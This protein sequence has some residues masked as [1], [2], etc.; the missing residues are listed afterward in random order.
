MALDSFS[1]SLAALAPD[2]CY[3]PEGCFAHPLVPS[4]NGQLASAIGLPQHSHEHRPKRP[5]L[6]AVDQK[7]GEGRDLTQISRPS[8]SVPLH[9]STGSL[10]RE[11]AGALVASSPEDLGDLHEADVLW[12]HIHLSYLD[13]C[14]GSRQ[15]A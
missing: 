7:L 11:R 9:R 8:S 12:A 4:K 13:R 1:S 6:L 10:A 3:R 5:V 2:L 15:H 14:T